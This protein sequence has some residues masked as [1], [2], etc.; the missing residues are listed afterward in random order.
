MVDTGYWPEG[1]SFSDREFLNN[2]SGR[3]VFGPAPSTFSGTCMA[4]DSFPA[5]TCNRKVIGC[6]YFHDGVGGPQ[7]I[8]QLWPSESISCRAKDGLVTHGSHTS[9]TA[10]G[11]YNVVSDN[12]SYPGTMSGMAPAA[13]LAIYKASWGSDDGGYASDFVAAIEQAT[14]DGVDVINYSMGAAAEL[15]FSTP[16]ETA[17]RHAAAAGVFV[18]AA[19]RNTGPGPFSIVDTWGPWIMSVGASTFSR[20]YTA[21]LAAA[22]DKAADAADAADAASKDGVAP[23][24]EASPMMAYFSS[25]GPIVAGDGNLLKPDITSPGVSVVAQV[26][27]YNGYTART[28]SGTS[29][30]AP[31]VSGIAAL[32]M[33]KYPTWTPMAVKSAIMTTAYQTTRTG[34]PS[35]QTFGGPFDFGAGHVHATSALD[36]GLV[37]DSNAPDWQRFMC[38]VAEVPYDAWAQHAACAPCLAAL[39]DTACV[40]SS[41]EALTAAQVARCVACD[42][43]N[44]NT[45]SIAMSMLAGPKYI[46]RTLTN[47]KPTRANYTAVLDPPQGFSVKVRPRR[48]VAAAGAI[49]TVRIRMQKSSAATPYSVWRSGAITWVGSGGTRTR[50]PL[51]VRAVQLASR[52]TEVKL[53]AW[54]P[55]YSYV[56]EPEWT[57]GLVTTN[58]GL[59]ASKVFTGTVRSWEYSH[60]LTVRLPPG[61]WSHVRFATFNEDVSGWN[62]VLPDFSSINMEVFRP[63]GSSA[64]TS[65]NDY[66][67]DEQVDLE[68]APGGE[69]TVEI[70]AAPTETVNF[71][72]HVWFLNFTAGTSANTGTLRT[73]PGLSSPS[74]AV[75]G[76]PLR[77]NL[78]FTKSLGEG[79]AAGRRYLGA[80]LYSRRVAG[81]YRRVQHAKTLMSL[82]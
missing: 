12:P 35:H 2:G 53:K 29:M 65:A 4:G 60:R 11:N 70:S 54:Q 36:P 48:F 59:F 52:P 18:S 68:R 58:T 33:S 80:V 77:I 49:T 44:F 78:A 46:T 23:Q 56:V 76:A 61:T 72:V 1:P 67:S 41:Y 82:M 42:P 28:L 74:N 47:V 63:D 64:G 50:I 31:H 69:Y 25:R 10:A 37:I 13:R 39:T 30:S 81:V 9:S 15:S 19:C 6:R 21:P 79:S 45:P 62:G 24:Q 7:K 27:N 8:K 3:A 22:G 34:S 73:T 75:A 43:S 16:V 51:V 57:G 66:N 32:V 71:K 55:S 20:S 14:K 40:P 5:S 17:F 38:G 26:T